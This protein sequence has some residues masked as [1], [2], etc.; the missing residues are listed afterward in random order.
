[1]R[2][3]SLT[4]YEN[5]L[6]AEQFQAAVDG[7]RRRREIRRTLLPGGGKPEMCD[8]ISACS[9]G[10]AEDGATAAI[11]QAF[12]DSIARGQHAVVHDKIHL[13]HAWMVDD[14]GDNGALLDDDDNESD[15]GETRV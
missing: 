2:N 13:Q 1:M 6:Y 7:E 9:F 15:E 5:D 10:V 14:D 8:E 3:M 4:D 12:A 11:A